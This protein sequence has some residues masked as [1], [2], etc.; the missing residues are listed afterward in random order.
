MLYYLF[1][2]LEY[3]RTAIEANVK[4]FFPLIL[5][6]LVLLEVI[7]V[8]GPAANVQGSNN[9]KYCL[10]VDD[11]EGKRQLTGWW[12]MVLLPYYLPLAAAI[13]PIVRI[14][15]RLRRGSQAMTERSKARDK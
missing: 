14:T 1:V 15:W 8:A 12:F 10:F 9:L 13:L 11:G 4:R 3:K 2:L 6:G 5:V 7:F